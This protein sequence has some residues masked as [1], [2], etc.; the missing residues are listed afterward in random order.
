MMK[1]QLAGVK[2]T[3]ETLAD[4]GGKKCKRATRQFAEKAGTLTNKAA[5]R[6]ARAI[7]KPGSYREGLRQYARSLGKKVTQ[8]RGG[9][10]VTATVGVR[11]GFDVTAGT[12]SRGKRRGKPR[13]I[14]PNKYAHLIEWGTKRSRAI[15]VIDGA[16]ADVAPA[17]PGEFETIAS[18]LLN[19]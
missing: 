8:Y 10:I 15:G 13:M 2:E 7:P 1:L 4:L 12:F 17:L 6:R 5:K 18:K 16:V 9:T 3:L 11:E 14:R 19:G